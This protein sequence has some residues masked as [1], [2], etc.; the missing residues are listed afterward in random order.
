M[1]KAK[2]KKFGLRALNDVLIIREDPIDWEHDKRSGLT[3]EVV[4]AL[5]SSKLYVPDTAEDY[6]K[7]FP[8]TGIVLSVGSK[9]KFEIKAGDHVAYARLGVQRFKWEGENVCVVREADLHGIKE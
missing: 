9:C 1:K 5:K 3:K 2:L 4:D 6:V 7:K 8:C